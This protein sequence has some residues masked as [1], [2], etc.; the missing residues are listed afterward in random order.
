MT[1]HSHFTSNIELKHIFKCNISLAL[2]KYGLRFEIVQVRSDLEYIR[3]K[4][5]SN[6]GV[7][8]VIQPLTVKSVYQPSLVKFETKRVPHRAKQDD[9]S[10][11]RTPDKDISRRISAANVVCSRTLINVAMHVRNT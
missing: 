11:D 4:A 7:I 3:I 10:K 2:D 8:S 6:Y 1:L 9:V 5:S